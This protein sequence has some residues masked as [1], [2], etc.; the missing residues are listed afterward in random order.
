MHPGCC[1]HHGQCP[2]PQCWKSQ[3][4]GD[5][6]EV[7][8]QGYPLTTHS[9]YQGSHP[10]PGAELFPDRVAF[11]PSGHTERQRNQS[12]T[13]QGREMRGSLPLGSWATEETK[14]S[15]K[16]RE[17]GCCASRRPTGV[18]IQRVW[19]SKGVARSRAPSHTL[20]VGGACRRACCL[21]GV[22]GPQRR[23]KTPSCALPTP[24]PQVK[25]TE[26]QG[27]LPLEFSLVGSLGMSL[28]VPSLC[29]LI[30]KFCKWASL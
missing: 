5:C 3:P 29:F 13:F 24:A 12:S 28:L 22:P 19:P 6:K 18:V 15:P 9:T 16:L 2:L 23:G 27:P 4:F 10:S 30:C 11:S 20:S 7:L 1:Q 25:G 26:I 21:G 14:S 8:V 17:W